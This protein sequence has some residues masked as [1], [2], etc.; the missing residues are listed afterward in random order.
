MKVYLFFK[1]YLSII[2]ALILLFGISV[3]Q[4]H[5]EYT[6]LRDISVL[7]E[8]R[9]IIPPSEQWNKS[10]GGLLP[11]ELVSIQQSGDNGYIMTGYTYS[12]SQGK[13]DVWLVKTDSDGVEQWNASFGGTSHDEGLSV[14]ETEDK[15]YMVLG[16]TDSIETQST[17]VWLIKTDSYGN[18]L[19]DKTYGGNQTDIGRQILSIGNGEYVIIGISQTY[20]KTGCFIIKINSTGHT[21][22]NQSF[23]YQFPY[24]K[25]NIY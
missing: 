5:H 14:I 1:Y 23:D 6:S 20:E 13:E 25:I 12:Y 18:K 11:D 4:V 9:I 2:L 16:K 21:Q 19:W 22:W 24:S 10:F 17:D 7:V 3:A 8:H 15:G